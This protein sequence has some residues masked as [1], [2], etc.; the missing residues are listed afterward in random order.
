MSSKQE[1]RKVSSLAK[2][3]AEQIAKRMLPPAIVQRKKIVPSDVLL[4]NKPSVIIDSRNSSTSAST[5]SASSTSSIAQSYLQNNDSWT[6][7][8]DTISRSNNYN[9]DLIHISNLCT[10]RALEP[11]GP[12]VSSKP[13]YVDFNPLFYEF[14]KVLKSDSWVES[15][16]DNEVSFMSKTGSVFYVDGAPMYAFPQACSEFSM[17]SE[18][19]ENKFNSTLK[20]NV[21]G[22]PFVHP[23]SVRQRLAYLLE[24]EFGYSFD[25]L[26]ADGKV[27]K[28]Y[29]RKFLNRFIEF[30]SLDNGRAVIGDISVIIR[31]DKSIMIS[32]NV[33]SL[34]LVLA[35]DIAYNIVLFNIVMEEITFLSKLSN[36]DILE[37][38]LQRYL[39]GFVKGVELAAMACS[40]GMTES[41]TFSNRNFFVDNDA[42]V[43]VYYPPYIDNVKRNELFEMYKVENLSSLSRMRYRMKAFGMMV[44]GRVKHTVEYTV[45]TSV[46][47]HKTFMDGYFFNTSGVQATSNDYNE[48]HEDDDDDD[49]TT[50]TSETF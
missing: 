15:M 22:E 19:A 2:R 23:F 37:Y 9:E 16:N 4:G 5:S 11:E 29:I 32:S 46:Q 17:T 6:N 20:C 34:N 25:L 44:E 13:F 47:N 45:I 39:R 33:K 1:N 18:G 7:V 14:I 10:V 50:V 35:S 49:N 31:G 48:E 26:T 28:N 42:T 40:Y 24:R 27:Q 3:S 43:P 30:E 36:P 12:I 8:V 21:L 38:N 41:Y